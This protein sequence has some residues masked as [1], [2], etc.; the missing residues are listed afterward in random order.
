MEKHL[1]PTN[2]LLQKLKVLF[3]LDKKQP[4]VPP[5]RQCCLL[6]GILENEL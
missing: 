2:Q 3:L 6:I 4:I 5:V 1:T